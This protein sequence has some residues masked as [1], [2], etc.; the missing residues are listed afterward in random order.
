[1]SYRRF[2][3]LCNGL[4]LSLVL[5]VLF[6]TPVWAQHGS[7]GKVAVTVRTA[8]LGD[9]YNRVQVSANFSGEGASSDKAWA[10]P[11]SLWK[12]A[13]KGIL[14]KE[15]VSSLQTRYKPVQ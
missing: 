12:L 11:G 10:Q 4:S 13:S 3:I 2:P 15:L 14:E 8:D 7:D 5:L 9:G 1:M 6:S